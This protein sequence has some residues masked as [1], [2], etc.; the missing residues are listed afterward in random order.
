LDNIAQSYFGVS[1]PI[2][3]TFVRK[4]LIGA[5]A[6][7]LS[8][9]CKL[10]T[11][12]ILQGK[13]GFKKSTFFKI[14]AGDY[15][16]DSLGSV[17]DKDERLKLHRSWFI[18]WSELESI[19]KRRDVSQTKAFLSSSIDAVR[20]PYCRDTQDFA[21]AS[22]I[23]ATTKKDEFLSDETGNRRFWII[24]VKKRIDTK[25][26]RQERDAIWAAA[27]LAYKSG[28]Q[29]WLDYEDEE[30]AETLAGE[31]RT[32]D[33]WMDTITNYTEYREWLL[34]GDLLNHLQVDL[35]R[36]ERSHQMRVASILKLLGW[37]KNFRTV[38]GKRCR[39][40][41]KPEPDRESDSESGTT[42]NT[43]KRGV[44]HEDGAEDVQAEIQSQQELENQTQQVDQ[45]ELPKTPKKDIFSKTE[46]AGVI[47]ADLS[48][49]SE[50]RPDENSDSLGE[51]VEQVDRTNQP[52]SQQAFQS[53]RP[54]NC[55]V[56]R[57]E[58]TEPETEAEAEEAE[59]IGF[60][61]YAI[62]ENDSQFAK[63]IQ[64]ILRDVCSAGAADRQ[65]VWASLTEAEKSAF[66]AL[67][68][69]P[70]STPATSEP[71]PTPTPEP[72]SEP[73]P[74]P[75]PATPTSKSTAESAIESAATPRAEQVS[76]EDAEKLRDIALIWWPEYYPPANASSSNTNVWLESASK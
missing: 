64:V 21:R 26:L 8:P 6:R 75:A 43:E 18:E 72:T 53:D 19:F 10:D 20:P 48:P 12:L 5:V 28:E 60:I 51:K 66:T 22:I 57:P 9:G 59:L 46:T 3:Q 35:S 1:E 7:A 42:I 41:C 56:D 29:W 63:E 73:T 37:Q 61:R 11:A 32:S 40:W 14:L 50:F 52:Q 49:N 23:V 34:M 62:A 2:Y 25:M 17:S 76:E 4:S 69:T 58:E 47:N 70:E 44:D 16:D 71:E 24:P 55:E 15:F 33:P 27:V 31:F 45:H 30:K 39:V 67:L 13:Q 54:D 74:V 68:S 36:Q 38:A 65:T